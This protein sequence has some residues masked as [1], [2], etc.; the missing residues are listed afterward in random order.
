MKDYS[1]LEEFGPKKLRTLRNQLNN[2][3]AHFDGRGDKADQ[4]RPSH[5]LYGLGEEACR[6]LLRRVQVEL[7][8]R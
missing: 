1:N 6:E 2:R 7:K 8:E 3:L 4:L 5:A